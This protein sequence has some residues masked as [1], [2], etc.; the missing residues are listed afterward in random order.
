MEYRY[1]F[2]ETV[3]NSSTYH[4]V[5]NIGDIQVSKDISSYTL[6]NSQKTMDLITKL[7]IGTR[8]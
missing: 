1:T 5:T 7:F 6:Y 4:E 3:K 2:L 8:I